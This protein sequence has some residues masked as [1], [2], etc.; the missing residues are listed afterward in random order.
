MA[1][2]AHTH[3]LTT[4]SDAKPSTLRLMARVRARRDGVVARAAGLGMV[5]GS[6][7]GRCGIADSGGSRYLSQLV[8]TARQTIKAEAIAACESY[9]AAEPGSISERICQRVAQLVSCQAE[10]QP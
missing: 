5:V 1:T 4:T 10:G 2:R 3:K 8:A 9:P 6:G 7:E